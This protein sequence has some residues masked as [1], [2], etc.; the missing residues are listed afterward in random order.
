MTHTYYHLWNI[1][2][3][4]STRLIVAANLKSLTTVLSKSVSR[5]PRERHLENQ[6]L[7]NIAFRKL[8]HGG[9]VEIQTIKLRTVIVSPPS[10]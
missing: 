9:A 7:S 2:Y 4:V 1:I 3:T 10:T 6:T 8:M 5:W